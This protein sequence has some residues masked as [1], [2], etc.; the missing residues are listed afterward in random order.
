MK[1]NNRT[2]L[3]TGGT[4]GMGLELAKQLLERKRRNTVIITSRSDERLENAKRVLPGV[5]TFKSDVG[6][7]AAIAALRDDVLGQFPTLDTL[8]NNAGIM[9]VQKFNQNQEIEDITREIEVCFSGPVRMVQHFMPH[10]KA[11]KDALLINVSSGAALIPFP[12]SPVYSAA[13]A[14]LH[15]FTESLR[16]QMRYTGVTVVELIPPG[17]E[18]PL[19][20][21]EEFTKEMKVPKGMEA[22]V[23]ARK[24]ISG[25]EAGK[26]E[27]RPGLANVLKVMSRMAPGFMLNQMGKMTPALATRPS[28]KPASVGA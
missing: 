18:T 27:I 6:D 1:L 15:S 7:P 22:S 21:S 10:L 3:I 8:I 5:S 12:I 26:L 17:V 16:V 28:A 23:F 11:R 14:G 9:R 19:F 25:I 24:A 4:S 13:K 2:I 20:R